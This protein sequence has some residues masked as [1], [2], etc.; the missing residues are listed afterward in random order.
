[1]RERA[2]YRI[3]GNLVRA[4]ELAEL[5]AAGM[6]TVVDLRGEGEDR[7]VV[8]GWS[9]GEGVE[10]VN[11]PITVGSRSGD[12]GAAMRRAAETGAAED[13]VRRTYETIVDDHGG[14]VAATIGSLSESFPS[15]FGCAAGKDRTGVVNACLHVL[16][17]V[18][19]D[20]AVDFYVARAP[21]VE[22]LRPMVCGLL[23]YA[24]P[25]AAPAGLDVILGARRST[26]LDVFERIQARWGGMEAYLEDHGL[27]GDRVE[28]LREHL[29]VAA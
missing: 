18:D 20:E 27:T 17:G 15:G 11:H 9:A 4:N 22:R 2:I 8:E 6:R 16:L 12:A 3:S 10:Y 29:V 19:E 25:G 21:S 28:R 7:S 14:A 5:D 24:D 13:Y 1:M 26:M 23:G